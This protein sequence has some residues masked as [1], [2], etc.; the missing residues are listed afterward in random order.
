MPAFTL[1][2]TDQEGVLNNVPISDKKIDNE[3][4]QS[5]RSKIIGRNSS[6]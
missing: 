2:F 4:K 1:V 3:K 6:I 5:S